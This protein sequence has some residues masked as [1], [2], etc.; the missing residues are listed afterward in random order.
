MCKSIGILVKCIFVYRFSLTS[1]FC[2]NSKRIDFL[3]LS[4]AE[5]MATATRTT[6]RNYWGST[7]LSK[8]SFFFILHTLV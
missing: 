6:D 7:F 2:D 1:I 5:T 4:V 3:L 8:Q